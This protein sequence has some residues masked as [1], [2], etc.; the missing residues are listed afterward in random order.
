MNRVEFVGN[1]L[2]IPFFLIGVGMLIDYQVF[3]KGWDTIM[4]AGV[5]IVIATGSKFLAAW[6][7]QQ[8]FRFTADERRLI[9]GLSNAQAAATLAAVLVGY[10]II[11]NQA[12]I[13]AGI[14]TEPMR[15]L[16][17]DVLNGTILMILVTCTIATL[18]AQKGAQ[19]IALLDAAD[20]PEGD[21]AELPEKILVPVNNP[22]TTEELIHLALTIKSRSNKTGLYALA[23][24][25]EEQSGSSADKQARKVL[26]KALTTAAAADVRLR[27]LLRYDLNVVNGIYGIVKEHQISDIIL[28]LHHKSGVSDNFYGYLTEG[29]LSKCNTTTLIYQSRQPLATIRRH[30]VFVPPRAEREIGFPFWLIK[31]W[32]IARNTGA[33]IVF[34]ADDQT[35]ATIRDIQSRHPIPCDFVSFDDW[36]D[37]LI[38]ARDIRPDDNMII[39]MSRKD[40]ISYNPNMPR[41]PEYLDKYFRDTSFIMVFPTQSTNGSHEAIDL[42]NPA[43]MESLLTLDD[44]GKTVARLFRRK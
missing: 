29:I 36:S 8:T 37:F 43:A 34:Y 9:F 13:N 35:L 5:M 7:T 40:R 32:N 33:K 39:V 26:T 31:T 20:A 22:D 1:A 16:N 25:D 44:I 27:D 23:V 2:F 41:I 19:N 18:S 42:T 15:L 28:G 6:L 24:L 3:F 30:L 14:A 10:N 12:D 17:D 21:G 4:V 11:L 38:V